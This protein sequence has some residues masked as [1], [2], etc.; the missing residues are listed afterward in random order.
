MQTFARLRHRMRRDGRQPGRSGKLVMNRTIFGTALV[1]LLLLAGC[2]LSGC[3]RGT[4]TGA[5]NRNAGG[6]ENGSNANQPAELRCGDTTYRLS[7]DKI[8]GE[9]NQACERMNKSYEA[10]MSDRSARVR[11]SC[12]DSK[13]DVVLSM[14]VR[15]ELLEDY[16]RS[17]QQFVAAE[18]AL[19]NSTTD[20]QPYFQVL[21]KFQAETNQLTRQSVDAANVIWHESRADKTALERL[22]KAHGGSIEIAN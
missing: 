1:A 4:S 2:G 7:S 17:C 15:N 11:F 16:N 19:P 20:R 13:G 3:G 18:A 21:R 5:G 8:D 12:Q 6:T 14:L 10:T 9:I 22:V